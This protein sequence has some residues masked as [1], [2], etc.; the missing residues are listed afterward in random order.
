MKFSQPQFL[1]AVNE[2]LEKNLEY[3]NVHPTRPSYFVIG[4]PRSGTTILTQLITYF[5]NVGFIDNLAAS[6]WRT[7]EVGVL[8]SRKLIKEHEFV[9]RSSF[10]GTNDIS[11]P[12]EFGAFWRRYLG[13]PDT[14]QIE[15]HK[16]VWK[17][18]IEK[19]DNISSIYELPVIY[20]VF[21]LMWH[22]SEFHTLKPDS[23]WIWITRNESENTSSILRYRII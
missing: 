21:Q 6:F 7:P 23:K 5:A 12:H 19:L 22:L 13:Y 18:L 20:K 3:S 11:E 9:G 4:A 17:P 10:G 2:V 14:S 8:L 16:V 1:E 15:N